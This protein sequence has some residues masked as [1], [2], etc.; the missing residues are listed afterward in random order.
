MEISGISGMDTTELAA[1]RQAMFSKL[2]TNGD[3]V[4]DTSELAAM[5]EQVGTTADQILADGDTD[6]DGVM[7]ESE[8]NALKPEEPPPLPPDGMGGKLYS[9]EEETEIENLLAAITEAADED[10]AE[11]KIKDLISEF[12][13]NMQTRKSGDSF[14]DEDTT[15]LLV[16]T[17]A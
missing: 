10:D 8:M 6:E 2:D 12:M 14:V 1:M 15:G 9:K 3:G 17:Y 13:E 7:S 4:L 11:T 5:A 16:D